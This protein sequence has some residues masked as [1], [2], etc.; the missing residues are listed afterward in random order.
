M[1]MRSVTTSRFVC[2]MLVIS[3]TLVVSPASAQQQASSIAG[4]VKDTSGAVL[5]GVT[6]EARSPV[7]I[8]KVRTAVSDGDGQYRITDL[9]PGTYGLTFSLPGFN[10]VRREG[11]T[12]TAAFA[13][14]INAELPVGALEET[15]TVSG[16]SPLVD[17]QNVLQRKTVSDDLL[18]TLPTSTITLWP[19]MAAARR[20]GVCGGRD[21]GRPAGAVRRAIDVLRRR[22][23]ER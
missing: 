8:E 9:P 14:T 18:Q 1:E 17:V 3:A 15:V 4:L 2:L 19:P 7:L 23:Q 5:P 12:L 20:A 10:T 21:H 13:A 6:V 11:V 22:P 16:A